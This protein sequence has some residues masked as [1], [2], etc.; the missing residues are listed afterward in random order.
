M[1]PFSFPCLVARQIVWVIF[2]L[3][4]VLNLTP[5]I[6]F[7]LFFYLKAYLRHT[8][9]FRMKPDGS[10]VTSLFLGNNRQHQPV[11]AKTIS[12]WVRKVLSVAKAHMSL[13]SLWGVAASAALA[14]GV[15][16]VTILQVGAWTRVSTPARH[17]FSSC[18][19]TGIG[20]RTLCSMPCWA[21]VSRP[22]PGKCQTL[23]Y[24][25]SC[26]CWAVG[27]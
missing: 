23:T 7:A 17:Y 13:G 16:L 26:I 2:P 20:T 24:N 1:L 6:I 21:S 27:P 9:S 19:T 8:E 11:C 10:H 22:P 14:A 5:M 18:I 12:S 4:F 15:F 3:R 25:Q